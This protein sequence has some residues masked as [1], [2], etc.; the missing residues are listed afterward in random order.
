MSV[1]RA[2][3]CLLVLAM[4][5]CKAAFGQTD[6]FSQKAAQG[7]TTEPQC[8]DFVLEAQA[9]V[10]TCRENTMGYIRCDDA[11]ADLGRVQ[12]L[13]QGVRMTAYYAEER[14][15]DTAERR[16]RR[17]KAEQDE[18]AAAAEQR[19]ETNAWSQLH[20]EACA[21]GSDA[22]AC[23]GTRR[24]LGD[25]PNGQHA[26]EARAS[27]EQSK[28]VILATTRAAAAEEAR[29]A[30]ERD[31]KTRVEEEK[32]ATTVR[33]QRNSSRPGGRLTDAQVR[34]ILIRR[35]IASYPGP[36]PCPYNVARNGSQCGSRSAWSRPGGYEP[37]CFDNDVKASMIEEFR[38]EG[39]RDTPQQ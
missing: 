33:A 31:E 28:E 5:G 14:R 15:K 20:L 23:E 6:G 13:L 4:I 18:I 9:R 3:R 29:T 24:F 34:G 7:C 8:Q 26:A 35:S 1:G 10:D 17:E 27:L 30:V 25:H 21:A 32:R 39:E 16:Q 37:L 38:L 2:P 19:A 22:G 11:R 12:M 36:C